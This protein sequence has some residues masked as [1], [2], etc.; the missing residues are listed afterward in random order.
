MTRWPRFTRP[1]ASM[2][3]IQAMG[4]ELIWPLAISTLSGPGM[5]LRESTDMQSPL[6]VNRFA[7]GRRRNFD[8]HQFTFQTIVPTEVRH[9]DH[10]HQFVQ[11]VHNLPHHPRTPVTHQGHP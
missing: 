6:A 11:L 2:V 5:L 9:A 8:Q 4:R 1:D 3:V 7:P 10:V